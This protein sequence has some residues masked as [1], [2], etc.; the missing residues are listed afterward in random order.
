MFEYLKDFH[1]IVVTGPQRSGTRIAS[2]MIS[3]DTGKHHIDERHIYIDS[4]YRFRDAVFSGGVIQAPALCRFCHVFGNNDQYAVV[5]MRRPI[6]DIIASQER[7]NWTRQWE[8]LELAYYNVEQGPIA[9]VKYE[10][11]QEQKQAINHWFEVEYESLRDHRLWVPKQERLEFAS[12]Q[13]RV[14]P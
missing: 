8:P 9:R 6:E 13:T 2:K 14:L 4:L 7:I 1:A 3:E 11:W 5:M 12:H 10:F